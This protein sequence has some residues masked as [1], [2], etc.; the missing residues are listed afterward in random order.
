M[1]GFEALLS[2][3]DTRGIRES[4][5]HSMLQRVETTFKE[6]LKKKTGQFTQGKFIEVK[7]LR[8]SSVDH[9]VEND[10]PA[11]VV[12]GVY[13]DVPE[14]SDS[15]K[16]EVGGN[17]E[18]SAALKRYFDTQKW[19]WK[20]CFNPLVFCAMKHGKKRC[21]ELLGI[22]SVCYTTYFCNDHHCRC[23]HQIFGESKFDLNFSEHLIH[24]EEERQKGVDRFN[25]HFAN[26][27]SPTR[28]ELLKA[29]LALIEVAAFNVHMCL[30]VT[31][32]LFY[33]V[34]YERSWNSCLPFLG[35]Y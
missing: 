23:C 13:T 21:A 19:L 7:G 5:L 31:A 26:S 11:S 10:S 9:I 22:C 12:C 27:S 25:L 29:K 35:V 17:E 30:Y 6:T 34:S 16:I 2:S 1:Q 4:H 33:L 32:Q 24:C 15:F 18:R 3:L 28:I 8:S 14:K 20:E